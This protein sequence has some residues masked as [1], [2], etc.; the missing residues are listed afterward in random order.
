MIPPR[1]LSRPGLAARFALLFICQGFVF[2][3]VNA[4]LPAFSPAFPPLS[5]RETAQFPVA[6]LV[7]LAVRTGVTAY[8]VLRA[9]ATGWRLAIGLAA[10][11]FYLETVL[12]QVEPL[13]FRDAFPLL[14]NRNLGLIGLSSLLEK[15]LVIPLAVLLLKQETTAGTVA[16]DSPARAAWKG[17]IGLKNLL[18]LPLLYTVLYF[19]AGYFI[20]WQFPEL[21]RFYTGREEILGFW[22]HLKGVDPYFFLFQYA[23]GLGWILGAMLLA[24]LFRGRKRAY[25]TSLVL[26]CCVLITLPLILP[27]AV[28]PLPVRMAHIPEMLLSMSLWTL[29]LGQFTYLPTTMP[30]PAFK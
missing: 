21:R 15:A 5:A 30:V 3:L 19:V 25:V 18:A 7:Y 2:V 10:V 23:R 20:A 9:S 8:L 12:M 14:S 22:D 11:L 27:N 6:L 4:A 29:C 26:I 1:S 24:L 28:M 13:W 16:A 17:T